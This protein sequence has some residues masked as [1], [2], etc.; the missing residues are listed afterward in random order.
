MNMVSGGSEFTEVTADSITMQ[1]TP[2]KGSCEQLLSLQTFSLVCS[3]L[4]D[5]NPCGNE[6]HIIQMRHL[7][8]KFKKCALKGICGILAKTPLSQ[9]LFQAGP[10]MMYGVQKPIS[11]GSR[12][13]FNHLDH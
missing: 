10:P 6:A 9:I 7:N 4:H 13:D 3:T 12:W 8:K 2:R 11:K 1:S 5:K